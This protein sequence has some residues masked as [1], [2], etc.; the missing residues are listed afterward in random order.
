MT[1][2]DQ[3]QA[4]V[5]DI[6]ES[7]K[8]ASDAFSAVEYESNSQINS[9]LWELHSAMAAASK[10]TKC[11][12]SYTQTAISD[13]RLLSDINISSDDS[14]HE[15]AQ[16]LKSTEAQR[17]AP[18][19]F[20]TP[21]GQQTL[22]VRIENTL[23]A[24]IKD[25]G[26]V[27]ECAESLLQ[28][29]MHNNKKVMEF[30]NKHLNP[31]LRRDI[32]RTCTEANGMKT[33]MTQLLEKTR[34]ESES[35]ALAIAGIKTQIAE[36]DA[37]ALRNHAT[38]QEYQAKIVKVEAQKAEAERL[39]VYYENEASAARE[40]ADTD[41]RNGI[42][43]GVFTLGIAFG[44][45]I[46]AYMYASEENKRAEEYAA[47]ASDLISEASSLKSSFDA[48]QSYVSSLQTT[49]SRL[50]GEK[51]RLEQGIQEKDKLQAGLSSDV[52]RL[53]GDVSTATGLSEDITRMEAACRKLST[54]A[55]GLRRN[56]QALKVNVSE[57]RDAFVDHRDTGSQAVRRQSRFRD[58]E[59]VKM[60]A[61][62]V[63]EILPRI[64]E[65]E[66]SLPPPEV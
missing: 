5:K 49:K 35:T 47:Q 58:V 16:L 32:A 4:K 25:F 53:R 24:I 8:T 27:I 15:Q 43:I 41:K 51:S 12:L 22:V 65:C 39:R 40:R 50:A 66:K 30:Q 28:L 54:N 14:V 42:L 20:D 55:E 18:N 59:K 29:S 10:G 11:L 13:A 21:Q 44:Y 46:G 3:L 60:L 63:Q 19:Q 17:P 57:C 23:T 34:K 1:S 64:Q 56:L 48:L 62:V 9:K 61:S 6:K 36:N 37:T 26:V 52:V 38:L 45:T 31:N 2:R 33:A 7:L